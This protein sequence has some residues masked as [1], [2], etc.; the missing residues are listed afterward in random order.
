MSKYFRLGALITTEITCPECQYNWQ[1]H[2]RGY[3]MP[4]VTVEYK[5]FCWKCGFE[6][7]QELFFTKQ[8][9]LAGPPKIYHQC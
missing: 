2:Y 3:Q 4:M 8:G 5:C 6:F 1:E 7:Y 9:C